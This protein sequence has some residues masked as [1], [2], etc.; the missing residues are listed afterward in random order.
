MFICH[1]STSIFTFFTSLTAVH[2]KQT[3]FYHTPQLHH[4]HTTHTP[5]APLQL[6]TTSAPQWHSCYS[7]PLEGRQ[8]LYFSVRCPTRKQLNPEGVPSRLCLPS[9][10]LQSIYARLTVAQLTAAHI[11]TVHSPVYLYM[12]D[13]KGTSAVPMRVLATILECSY[14]TTCWLLRLIYGVHT[15]TCQTQII[16]KCENIPLNV[17][18][19]FKYLQIS[20]FFQY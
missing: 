12:R 17:R 10:T 14:S 9:Q 1:P 16:P 5:P 15:R 11:S 19:V 3:T 4:P 8:Q 7:N 2:S 20:N 18:D 13:I 6:I